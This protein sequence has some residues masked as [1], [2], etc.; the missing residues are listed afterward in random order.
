MRVALT[1]AFAK[2]FRGTDGWIG[3]VLATEGRVNV[4]VFDS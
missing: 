3:I 2:R 1:D 4:E